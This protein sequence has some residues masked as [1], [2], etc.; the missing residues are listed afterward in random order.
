M[1]RPSCPCVSEATCSSAPWFALSVHGVCETL[2]V[3]KR[4][5]PFAYIFFWEAGLEHSRNNFSK[6][7]GHAMLMRADVVCE[8]W[9]GI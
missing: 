5:D 4:C 1:Q 9:D 2:H 6:Q 3:H 8:M 7:D